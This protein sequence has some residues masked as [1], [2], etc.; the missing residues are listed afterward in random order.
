M[1]NT[2][3]DI[4]TN[5]CPPNMTGNMGPVWIAT[6]SGVFMQ[7][8]GQHGGD[9]YPE[10]FIC[11]DWPDIGGERLK[12]SWSL[13]RQPPYLPEHLVEFADANVFNVVNNFFKRWKQKS[14]P[15][16]YKNGYTNAFYE[17]LSWSE[18][19]GLHIPN[20]FKL[21][22]YIPQFDGNDK[23]QLQVQSVD[24]G[25]VN[26]ITTNQLD[27][28]DPLP[29]IA[30][31]SRI[32]EYRYGTINDQPATYTS[33]TGSLLAKSEVLKLMG[34]RMQFAEQSNRI[35]SGRRKIVL[36]CFLCLTLLPIC[37]LLFRRFGRNA[38]KNS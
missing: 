32:N 7:G 17:V 25:F 23:A 37:I 34:G 3:V 19:D 2:F 28:I 21:T 16:I 27:A 20:H 6:A 35:A 9:M 29:E 24:E 10:H 13:S 8:Q 18:A 5:A 22:S 15:Q 12:A 14:F 30:T 38:S 4:F 11:P 36:V 31:W 26:T 1:F 33:Q